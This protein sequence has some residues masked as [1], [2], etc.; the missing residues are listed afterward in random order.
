M[1]YAVRLCYSSENKKNP[2]T[3]PILS[4]TVTI[5]TRTQRCFSGETPLWKTPP[6]KYLF[7]NFVVKY[8]CEYST[9]IISEFGVF[10]MKVKKP[11]KNINQLCSTF[12]V[13]HAHYFYYKPFKIVCTLVWT[14]IC[15]AI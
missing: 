9:S 14:Y 8:V 12:S 15:K 6:E 11:L 7:F 4:H 3:Y 1:E 2:K 5:S 10:G 13:I